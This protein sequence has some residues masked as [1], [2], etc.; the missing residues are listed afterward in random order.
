MTRTV[1]LIIA[2]VVIGVV[3]LWLA[4]EWAWRWYWAAKGW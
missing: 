1:T 4:A 2:G 3:G